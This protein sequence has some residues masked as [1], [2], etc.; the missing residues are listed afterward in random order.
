MIALITCKSSLVPLLEGLCTSNP[1]RFVHTPLF[2]VT[3]PQS[4]HIHPIH[5]ASFSCPKRIDLLTYI[6]HSQYK[7]PHSRV[8]TGVDLPIYAFHSQYIPPYSPRPNRRQS[9][10]IHPPPLKIHTA[11]VL[12]SQPAS[13]SP[14]THPT[15][16]PYHL[17]LRDPTSVNLLTY[18]PP[19][20]NTNNLFLVSQPASISPHILCLSSFPSPLTLCVGVGAWNSW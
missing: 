15:H 1:C 16:S 2:S 3:Q 6:P 14:Y 9:P 4:P 11:I 18:T 17:T 19:T 5:T 8:P 13:I 7:Q 12:V 10:H 20:H